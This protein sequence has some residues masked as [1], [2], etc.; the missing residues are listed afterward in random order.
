MWEYVRKLNNFRV[1]FNR[2]SFYEKRS[3]QDISINSSINVYIRGIV[4]RWLDCLFNIWPFTAPKVWLFTNLLA[5]VCSKFQQI[6]KFYIPIW[7]DNIFQHQ[8]LFGIWVFISISVEKSWL[9]GANSIKPDVLKLQ[10]ILTN[11][12]Y[13]MGIFQIL[14]PNS[15]KL[16]KDLYG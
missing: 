5:K 12:F 13:V 3:N 7:G 14:K 2:G 16:L 9:Q 15:F 11:N 8:F 6:C 1:N 10:P 4:N